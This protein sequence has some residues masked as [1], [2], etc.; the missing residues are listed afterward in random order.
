[1]QGRLAS[2]RAGVDSLLQGQG[3]VLR[4]EAALTRLE[5]LGGANVPWL[6]QIPYL[7]SCLLTCP[8]TWQ[9]SMAPSVPQVLKEELHSM[10]A[11]SPRPE[12]QNAQSILSG[13]VSTPA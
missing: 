7:D 4:R 6:A 2:L 8:D 11:Y 10:D 13:Q 1:M 5:C 12:T 3:D 9:M